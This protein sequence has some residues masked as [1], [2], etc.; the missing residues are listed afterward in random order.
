MP[1]MNGYD[2]LRELRYIPMH[3]ELPVVV[4]S[5]RTLAKHREQARSLGATEFVTKPFSGETLAGV[6]R[7]WARVSAIPGKKE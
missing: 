1:R 3:R 4:V 6:I 5:S 2:L 7:K